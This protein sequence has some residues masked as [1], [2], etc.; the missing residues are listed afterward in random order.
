VGVWVDRKKANEEDLE[1]IVPAAAA[2]GKGAPGSA[3][4]AAKPPPPKGQAVEEA[5]ATTETSSLDFSKPID[6]KLGTADAV[7]NS[8]KP[9]PNIY[10]Q[11]L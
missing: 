11:G 4:G 6:Y 9:P 2:A 1:G 3:K 8:S 7:A 10:I 5:E